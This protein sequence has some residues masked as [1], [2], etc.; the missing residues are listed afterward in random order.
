M[1][2]VLL[3][4]VLSIT[5]TVCSGQ[6]WTSYGNNLVRY[7]YQYSYSGPSVYETPVYYN[8]PATEWN[9]PQARSPVSRTSVQSTVWSPEGA[10][11]SG[12]QTEVNH[13]PAARWANSGYGW[14]GRGLVNNG[15]RY[16]STPVLVSSV[17]K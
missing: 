2:G 5:V 9:Y 3:V 10:R 14:I 13:E 16:I 8:V 11:V 15:V 17:K 6:A 4:A 1:R 7:P 12:Y